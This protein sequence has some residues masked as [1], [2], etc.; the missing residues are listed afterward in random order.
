M[1]VVYGLTC[2][3]YNDATHNV[4]LYIFISDIVIYPDYAS[5]SVD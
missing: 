2:P 3:R 4:H 5:A 1:R